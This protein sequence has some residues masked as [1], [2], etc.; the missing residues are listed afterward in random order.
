[1]REPFDTMIQEGKQLDEQLGKRLAQWASGA[2]ESAAPA[3]K[4]EVLPGLS[5]ASGAQAAADLITPDQCAAIETLCLDSGI[6]IAKLKT[7][8]K[9]ER[10]AQIRAD[11]YDKALAWVN[12]VKDARAAA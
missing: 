4:P 5:G 6:P 8:A 7:A 11:E 12:K 2:K 1:M 3:P 9:V 10:L